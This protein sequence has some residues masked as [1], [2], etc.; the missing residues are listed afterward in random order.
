MHIAM[1]DT[2]L[3]NRRCS[4]HFG[5]LNVGAPIKYKILFK[6][7]QGFLGEEDGGWID[8]VYYSPSYSLSLPSRLPSPKIN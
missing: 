1:A 5:Q 3:A 7:F 4:V 6:D 2:S 8:T